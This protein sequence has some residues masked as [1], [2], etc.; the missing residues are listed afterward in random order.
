MTKEGK[1]TIIVIAT[2]IFLVGGLV[3][4]MTK[5]TTE[6]GGK[7]YAADTQVAGVEA[8]PSGIM[9]LGNIAYKG[10][11]VTKTFDVKN[12]S[13]KTLKLRKISTSCMC[14]RAKFSVNGKESK[15][16]GMEMSGD[17]NPLIDIDLPAG[18]TAQVTFIF[19]PAAHGLQGVGAVDRQIT[20]FFDSGYKT[21]EFGGTVV[22]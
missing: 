16:Y 11:T 13:D 12:T 8:N 20:V 21:L 5:S 18:Q 22:N 6:V 10:G 7:A 15:F 1:I 2:T 14:T 3:F 4:L 9:A 19:D 17:L